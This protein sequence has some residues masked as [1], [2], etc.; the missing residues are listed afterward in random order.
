M[1]DI[2][3][4]L[5]GNVHVGVRSV[6]IESAC[7]LTILHVNLSNLLITAFLFN[8]RNW[9]EDGSKFSEEFAADFKI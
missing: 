4:Y 7:M 2:F 6:G 5:I 3:A 9:T 8:Y 1:T